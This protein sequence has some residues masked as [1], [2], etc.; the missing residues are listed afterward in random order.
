MHII[1]I[2][3]WIS[4]RLK[5]AQIRGECDDAKKGTA[6]R[7]E[8][9]EFSA[10]LCDDDRGGHQDRGMPVAENQNAGEK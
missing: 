3:C 7:C 1:R 2:N 9:P 8:V 5:A 4:S 6:Q 10:A